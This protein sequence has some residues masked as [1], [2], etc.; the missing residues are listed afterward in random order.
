MEIR[1]LSGFEKDSLLRRM[2][3]LLES[4]LDGELVMLNIERGNYYGLNGVAKRIWELLDQP[5]S[6]RQLCETLQTEFDV[7]TEQCES[8]VLVFLQDLIKEG[9]V[10]VLP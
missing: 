2:P 9:I 5:R 6:F 8:D 3:G 7:A 1:I 10:Q 4:P